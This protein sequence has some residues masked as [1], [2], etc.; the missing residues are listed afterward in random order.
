MGRESPYTANE[1]APAPPSAAAVGPLLRSAC[2][3]LSE[4]FCAAGWLATGSL[5]GVAVVLGESHPATTVPATKPM[6]VLDRMNRGNC[7]D[8]LI[9]QPS[10]AG[11]R[12]QLAHTWI[13]RS[14]PASEPR[15]CGDAETAH[16]LRAPACGWQGL[17]RVHIDI[18]RFIT[19]AV[20]TLPRRPP[21]AVR[22]AVMLRAATFA[23]ALLHT[24]PARKHLASFVQNP[25]LTAGWKGFGALAAVVVLALPGHIQLA[26]LCAARRRHRV[27]LQ[28]AGALLAAAHTVPASDHLP[29]LFEAPTWSDAWRGV[30]SSLAV[31]WFLLPLTI[32]GHLVARFA[33]LARVGLAGSSLPR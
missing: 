23:L 6:T 8:V 28:A 25:C 4:A 20:T 12:L 15:A 32:Q 9:R 13:E 3:R 17:R 18:L 21:G 33:R 2:S 19:D 11:P 1:K 22:K 5:R 14:R 31:V 7:L 16:A 29:R 10:L 27:L 30:G 26:M 24:F